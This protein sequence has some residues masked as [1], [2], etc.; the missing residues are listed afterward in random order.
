MVDRESICSGNVLV[1][2]IHPGP[3]TPSARDLHHITGSVINCE[4][5]GQL[6]STKSSDQCCYMYPGLCSSAV[7]PV[8]Q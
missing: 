5:E 3:V 8:G 2:L 1:Q 6:E 4:R 7:G